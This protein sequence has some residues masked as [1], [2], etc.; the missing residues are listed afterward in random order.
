V[1]SLEFEMTD[2]VLL[3]DFFLFNFSTNYGIKNSGYT[4]GSGYGDESL[5]LS[6]CIG[7]TLLVLLSAYVYIVILLILLY[8]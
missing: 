5:L 4:V 7:L 2:S 1:A 3:A 8:E 6:I